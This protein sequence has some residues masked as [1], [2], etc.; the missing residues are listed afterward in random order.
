L[1]DYTTN[2]FIFD[3]TKVTMGAGSGLGLP[4]AKVATAPTL[5]FRQKTTVA[6]CAGCYVKSLNSTS[7]T[8]ARGPTPST[9]PTTTA[10]T[11]SYAGGAL[12]EF[13][14][15]GY[16]SSLVSNSFNTGNGITIC[17]N[18]CVISSA[19]TSEKTICTVPALATTESVKNYAIAK[20]GMMDIKWTGTASATELAK[21]TNKNN[22]DE[23]KDS[24]A[25]CKIA[26]VFPTGFKAVLDEVS[27][28]A[29]RF[30]T[31]SEKAK[32]AG[33]LSFEGS[34][35]GTA[36]TKIWEVKDEVHVG[37]NTKVFELE[38]DK[39]KY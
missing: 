1:I 2:S 30:T 22:M 39:P 25:A 18:T 13:A 8:M 33:K 23:Y 19:S 3:F 11:S 35:D 4:Y 29:N 31:A 26:T 28:F 12:Y 17:G 16:Y 6:G 37:W 14:G 15:E 36:W 34:N 27:F 24:N 10:V 38:A 9:A 21:L 5:M 32:I 7:K 20:P